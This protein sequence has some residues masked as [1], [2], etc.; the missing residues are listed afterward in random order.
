[1]FARMSEAFGT[2]LPLRWI[3][4]A[5]SVRELARRVDAQLAQNGSGQTAVDAIAAG[6]GGRHAVSYPQQGLWFLEQF[7]GP[8]PTYNLADVVRI[9][10]VLDVDV[11]RRA[12][13][14]LFVRH[15]ALR[16]RFGDDDGRPFV[17]VE[18]DIPVERVLTEHDLR[19]TPEG[20]RGSAI[21]AILRDA[22]SRPFDLERAPLLRVV[23][24]RESDDNCVLALVVHHLVADGWSLGVIAR[25][26]AALYAGQ[27]L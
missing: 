6:A 13:A 8:G 16:S 4:E 14:A 25:D 27:T 1:L 21:D 19:A 18:T 24:V 10:G 5:P 23:L 7:E 15:D 11:L 3:F 2:S 20:E 9:E 22:A 26:L 17:E 12:I